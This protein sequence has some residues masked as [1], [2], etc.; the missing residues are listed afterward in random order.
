MG[1]GGTLEETGRLNQATGAEDG[2][3]GSEVD[4]FHA[5]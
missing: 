1:R 3:Q 4:S 2:G 5:S